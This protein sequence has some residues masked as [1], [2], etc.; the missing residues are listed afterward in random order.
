MEKKNN[1]RSVNI[2]DLFNMVLEGNSDF[3]KNLGRDYL[4]DILIKKNW[5]YFVYDLRILVKL[6]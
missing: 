4:C 5:F 6:S 3:I 2:G 1:E